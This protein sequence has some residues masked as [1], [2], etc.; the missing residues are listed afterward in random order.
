MAYYWD[1]RY[2]DYVFSEQYHDAGGIHNPPETRDAWKFLSLF[3]S[4]LNDFPNLYGDMYDLVKGLDEERA[5]YGLP[6]Q[7]TNDPLWKVDH[8]ADVRRQR[9]RGEVRDNTMHLGPFGSHPFMGATRDLQGNL[10]P[11]PQEG[12]LYP[13]SWPIT[14][15]E[16][17]WQYEDYLNTGLGHFEAGFNAWYPGPY[18]G[19]Y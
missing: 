7:Y 6:P 11:R 14:W 3:N 8:F 18:A 4:T 16:Y 13:V 5:Q 15:P 17:E 10:R 9:D 2:G 1:N 19:W 12:N